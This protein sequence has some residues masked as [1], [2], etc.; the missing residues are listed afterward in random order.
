MKKGG[1]LPAVLSYYICYYMLDLDAGGGGNF[2][3]DGVCL[4][5]MSVLSY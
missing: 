3:G 2:S 5:R 4:M 1:V